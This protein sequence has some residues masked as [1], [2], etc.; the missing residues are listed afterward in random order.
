MLLEDAVVGGRS[1]VVRSVRQIGRWV[2]NV[3][4]M[5]GLGTLMNINNTKTSAAA[6]RASGRVGSR[7]KTVAVY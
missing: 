6:T 2:Q 5:S 1:V 4:D 3:V 7:R